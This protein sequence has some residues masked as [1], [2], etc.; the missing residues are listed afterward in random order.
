MC[1]SDLNSFLFVFSFFKF[2]HNWLDPNNLVIF[3]NSEQ[4]FSL[5][6][7]YPRGIQPWGGTWT[8]FHP[9][10]TQA[11]FQT[12][13]LFNRVPIAH[14]EYTR[15]LQLTP[16]P[17]QGSSHSLGCAHLLGQTIPNRSACEKACHF[18][19]WLPQGIE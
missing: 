19:Q 2:I 7:S 11:H 15:V 14:E 16:T 18:S 1:S 3:L 8:F 17:R 6:I 13:S 4:P 12:E 9:T 5:C 10:V